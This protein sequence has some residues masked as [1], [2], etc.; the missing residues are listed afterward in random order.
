MLRN[1][2]LI[3]TGGFIGSIAR[4]LVSKLNL[5]ISIFSI[6]VGTLTVN[7]L[8]SLVIGFLAGMSEKTTILSTEARLFLMVGICG[9]FTTF[10]SFT[11]ENLTLM[12]NG[13]VLQVLIYSAA[14][15]ILG[16][17]AVYAGYV[18]SYLL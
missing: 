16:F 5:T 8:G 7:V 11:L 6:P 12:H 4:Y 2:L 9:G 1:L 18:L 3:G 15:L 17:A 14:S 13:L 10:S